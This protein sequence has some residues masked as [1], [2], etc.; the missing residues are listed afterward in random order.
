M[1]SNDNEILYMINESDDNYRIIL[2]K[3]RP[4]IIKIC[5]SYQNSFKEFGFEL[6][7]LIQIA[8]MAVVDAIRNYSDNKNTMFYTYLIH[9]IKNKILNESRKQRTNKKKVLNKALSYED[10]V[11][12]YTG[13]P[14]E[15]LPDKK[16]KDPYDILVEAEEEV[17]YINFLNSLPFEV[18][19]VYEMKQN[20]FKNK[21]ICLFLEIDIQELLKSM[22]YAKMELSKWLMIFN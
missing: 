2:D 11:S 19:L 9:C 4:L 18:A 7:D 5:S 14:L 13:N 17:N 6:E 12:G 22:K 10:I 16:A 3:Y 8:N 21:D 1:Y 15:I 20:G